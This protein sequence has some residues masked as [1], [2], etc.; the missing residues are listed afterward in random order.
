MTMTQ[1][2]M[3]LK[4][5]ITDHDHRN[6][7]ITKQEFSKLS[8]QIVAARLAQANLVSK[9]DIANFVTKTDLDD[10]LKILNQKI[11]SNKTKYAEAEKKITALTNKFEQL[12]EESHN[13]LLGRMYFTGNDSYQNFLAFTPMFSSLI[14]NSNKKV[15]N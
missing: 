9:S 2:L 6:N 11:T 8:R 7:Y 5:R 1:K 14:L 12:S 15:T 10:K 13:F 4:R 3:K